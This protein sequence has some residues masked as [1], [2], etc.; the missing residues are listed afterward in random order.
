MRNRR[1]AHNNICTSVARFLQR[2]FQQ[3][4]VGGQ[5]SMGASFIYVFGTIPAENGDAPSLDCCLLSIVYIFTCLSH[6]KKSPPVSRG[7]GVCYFKRPCGLFDRALTKQ[8]H[9]GY[10]CLVGGWEGLLAYLLTEL[11][12]G[13]TEAKN[14]NTLSIK[15]KTYFLEL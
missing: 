10:T 4:V 6:T 13:S 8:A 9:S 5:T 15:S 12:V 1:L 3:A 11:E 14:W 7:C 2:S